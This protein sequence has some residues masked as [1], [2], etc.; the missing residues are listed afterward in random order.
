M[1]NSNIQDQLEGSEKLVGLSSQIIDSLNQRSKLLKGLTNDEK[2]YLGYIKQQQKISED[3]LANAEKY[4]KV[5]FSSKDIAK[6]IAKVNE[7]NN[8]KQNAFDQIEVKLAEKRKAAVQTMIQLNRTIQAQRDR[9]QQTEND[10]ADIEAQRQI[11]ISKGDANLAKQLQLVLQGKKDTARVQEQNLQ[12]S[13]KE[14]E[15]QQDISKSIQ[16]IL[17]NEKLS[18]EQK[19]RELQFLNQQ[20]AVSKKVEETLGLSGAAVKAIIS[21]LDRLGIS[22]KHFEDLEEKMR[23]AAKSGNQWKVTFTA[24]GGLAKGIGKAL[25]D[26]VAI[27]AVL[28]KGVGKASTQITE[29]GKSFGVSASVANKIRQDIVGFSRSTGDAFVNTDRLLKA[30]TELSDQLGISVKFS[31]EELAS[32]SK[33]TEIIGLTA[34]E[35]AKLDL[36]SAG[37]GQNLQGYVNDIRTSVFYAQQATK[38]HFKDKDILQEISKLSA[39]TLVK[40]KENPKAIGEAVVEA[41][42][43]G[44]TL[45]NIDKMGESMLN[46]ESS[47]QSQMEAELLTGKALNL[48]KARYAA[49]TGDQLTLEKEIGSQVG[50]LADYQKQ[51]VI[52]QKSLAQAFG[53]SREEMSEMLLKQEAINKYGAQAGDLNKQ[54]LEDFQNS[55]KTLAQYLQDQETQRSIQEKFNDLVSKFQDMLVNITSGPLAQMIGGFLSILD[56]FKLIYPIAGAIGGIIVGK[57]VTGIYDFGKG[58]IQAIPKAATMLGLTEATAVAEITAAEAATLGFATIGIIAG[59]AAAVAAM[60]NAQ[61]SVSG[62]KF[63]TGGIV[64]SEINNATVG[65]AGP[66]AIIP[67]NSPKAGKMLG[68]VTGGGDMTSVVNAIVELRTSINALASRP[69]QIQVD[70][71][72][73]AN[74]VAKNVPTSYGNL[75]NPSSRVYGG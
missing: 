37:T 54:Q 30:Q 42:K 65:E 59:I 55:K 28:V 21:G 52:A 9:L 6:Q 2:T 19:E 46:F 48:E 3:I 70:G 50:S 39:G 56:T 45:E 64:T 29:L 26:P 60:N 11:A 58:L 13:K 74:T 49:L 51:N 23:E 20:L 36:A 7:E 4:E 75:L 24:I 5:Q 40:F 35:A 62:P 16:E 10:I 66:E 32:F 38:T 44:T 53:M 33:L 1:A 57:M 14:F 17:K 22:S 47:I 18:V 73:L 61:D 12:S 41:R 8:K 67:L 31:N 34:A 25:T 43:L 68:G 27:L 15:R 63:A 69:V 72:T 71:Q